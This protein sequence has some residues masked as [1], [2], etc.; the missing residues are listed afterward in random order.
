MESWQVIKEAKKIPKL[1]KPILI[2]GLPGIGNVGKLAVDFVI[3][4]LKA[5]KLYSLF[6][7][8]QNRSRC[9]MYCY[10]LDWSMFYIR[11]L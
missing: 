4:E 1:N 9:Q 10:R 7:Y 11:Y 5:E 8:S 2:E 6:S 3:D